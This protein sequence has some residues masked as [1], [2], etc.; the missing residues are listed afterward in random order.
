V[1]NSSQYE[2]DLKPVWWLVRSEGRGRYN[3]FRGRSI[4]Q[5]CRRLQQKRTKLAGDQRLIVHHPCTNDRRWDQGYSLVDIISPSVIVKFS[6]RMNRSRVEHLLHSSLAIISICGEKAS[7]RYWQNVIVS[8]TENITKNYCHFHWLSHIAVRYLH[9]LSLGDFRQTAASSN[10]SNN[11]KNAQRRRKHCALAV[12]RRSQKLSPR[13][14]PPSPGARNGQNLIS[15]YGM[16][17]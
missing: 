14:R 12:V 5:G 13:C 9:L 1:L 4:T 8:Y 6:Q 2:D 10:N 11:E 16:I 17:Y 15:W 7:L 3:E